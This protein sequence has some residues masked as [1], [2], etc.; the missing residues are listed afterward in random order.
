M[1]SV[2]RDRDLS[3]LSA[4]DIDVVDSRYKGSS[5]ILIVH[6]CYTAMYSL[7]GLSVQQCPNCGS[8]NQHMP[9]PWMPYKLIEA[10]TYLTGRSSILSFILFF[11][12]KIK[13]KGICWVKEKRANGE[14]I[15]KEKEI[16]RDALNLVSSHFVSVIC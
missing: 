2:A 6:A 15:E 9:A 11:V 3:E 1:V 7:C 8:Q 14:K 5:V 12:L 4:R 10:L 13:R 16:I